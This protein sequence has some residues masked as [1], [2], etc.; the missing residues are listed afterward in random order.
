MLLQCVPEL[1]LK[2]YVLSTEKMELQISIFKPVP[3]SDGHPHNSLD[4]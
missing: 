3:F 2:Y 1:C 4:M